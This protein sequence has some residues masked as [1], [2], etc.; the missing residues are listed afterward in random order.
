MTESDLGKLFADVARLR[1]DAEE[2][3]R[4]LRQ[5]MAGAIAE[6]HGG[7]HHLEVVLRDL[8]NAIASTRTAA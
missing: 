5:A 3:A 4:R 6:T 8:A 1:E 7:L 2:I